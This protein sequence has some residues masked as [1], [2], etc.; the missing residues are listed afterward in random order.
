MWVHH[1]GL[2]GCWRWLYVC[3]LVSSWAC[4][5]FG[6]AEANPGL[7]PSGKLQVTKWQ[8]WTQLEHKWQ[9][10]IH[11]T[12]LTKWIYLT[13][14]WLKLQ[15][16]QLVRILQYLRCNNSSKHQKNIHKHQWER[17]GN[18]NLT[19]GDKTW[20]EMHVWPVTKWAYCAKQ[21]QFNYL[22]PDR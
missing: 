8:K 16:E 4:P 17:G 1:I 21:W 22:T 13:Q 6:E 7:T 15:H 2:C 10:E 20:K 5:Q 3:L 11:L 12:K 9:S 14:E 19:K 18:L